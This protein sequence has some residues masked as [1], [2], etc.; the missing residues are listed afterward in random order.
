MTGLP[1]FQLDLDTILRTSLTEA[2]QHN[3]GISVTEFSAD[4]SSRQLYKSQNSLLEEEHDAV[5]KLDFF[6]NTWLVR[7]H[8]ETNALHSASTRSCITR[9]PCDN[10]S[11]IDLTYQQHPLQAPATYK[12]RP[13]KARNHPKDRFHRGRTGYCSRR[14]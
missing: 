5:E 6:G 14:Y 12:T 2:E 4:T 1:N 8:R 10:N 11:P 3:L 9:R 7:A 13:A